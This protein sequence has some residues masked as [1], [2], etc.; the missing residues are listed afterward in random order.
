V[1]NSSESLFQYAGH[2]PDVARFGQ[3]LLAERNMYLHTQFNYLADIGQFLTLSRFKDKSP[4][5]MRWEE[6]LVDDARNFASSLSK[7]GAG[8]ASLRRKISSLRSFF[9]YL[10]S[11]GIVQSNPFSGLKG[12]RKTQTLPRTFSCDE[13]AKFLETPRKEFE[14]GRIKKYAY[15]RDAAIF[16][17][18]YSTGC[19]ISEALSIKWKDLDLSRGSLIVTGK[20]S[21]ERLVILGEA[22]VA[23]LK[24]LKEERSPIFDENVFLND[25]FEA[26]SPRFIQRRMKYYLDAA[27]LP[28]NM[29]PHKFRHSFATHLLDAGAD[30]RSVQEMLGHSS[31]STTQI[32]THISV[33]RLKD[34][35]A[36]SHPRA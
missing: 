27:D 10:S 17:F 6:V 16:E 32:Y 9:R 24:A 28:P 11:L 5:N 8:A 20:G 18:L 30:L 2:F 35:Y 26:A 36:S 15:L 1:N 23:S 29:S 25:R 12:P 31:L 7:N 19:R 13:A 21:K 3:S 33:E 14:E 22:A 4:Q 34:A